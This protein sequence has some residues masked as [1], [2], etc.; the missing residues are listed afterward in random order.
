MGLLENDAMSKNDEYLD[1]VRRIEPDVHPLD[2]D[3]ALASIAISQRRQADAL[4]RIADALEYRP[5]GGFN[6]FDVLKTISERT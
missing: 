2:R 5:T 4:S 3:G 6:I 1:T